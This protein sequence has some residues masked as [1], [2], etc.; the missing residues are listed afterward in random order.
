MIAVGSAAEPTSGEWGVEQQ[1]QQVDDVDEEEGDDS[2]PLAELPELPDCPPLHEATD[3]SAQSGLA[4]HGSAV[5]GMVSYLFGGLRTKQ[6]S[7]DVNADAAAA[8]DTAAGDAAVAEV[9][10]GEDVVA[11]EGATD[12]DE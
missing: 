4:K 8:A 9:A 1:Q 11:G 10:V 2:V 12:Q 7:A 6:G 3:A 5:A